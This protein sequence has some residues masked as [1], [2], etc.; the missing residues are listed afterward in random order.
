MPYT[1]DP[2]DDTQ[3]LGS[4]VQAKEA[5]PEFRAIK[6][7][8]KDLNLATVTTIPGLIAA[9]DTRIDALESHSAQVLTGSGNFTVPAGVTK[10]YV[11]AQAG[12]LAE[13]LAWVDSQ[14]SSNCSLSQ[15]SSPG[16]IV[17]KELTVTPGDT[18]AY[19]AGTGEVIA[20]PSTHSVTRSVAATATTFGATITAPAPAQPA[21]VNKRF[22]GVSAA[23]TKSLTAG[24]VRVFN[25]DTS[26][27]TIY[28]TD[29]VTE[30]L[31]WVTNAGSITVFSTV[32]GNAGTILVEW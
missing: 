7:L 18:L 11:T 20:N 27:V 31:P 9:L 16:S 1:P 23:L 24:V 29:T 2:L 8:L 13:F 4:V 19:V 15:A 17:I 21:L 3:P 10:L 14:G 26:L 25:T 6:T 5:A 22:A 30:D 12:G 32:D 28:S